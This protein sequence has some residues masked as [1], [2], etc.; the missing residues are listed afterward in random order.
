[1]QSS[2]EDRTKRIYVCIQQRDIY[3]IV[4]ALGG[5]FILERCRNRLPIL[6]TG[7]FRRY[8]CELKAWK[9]LR[10]LVSGSE[11]GRIWIVCQFM[12][13]A[14]KRPLS[15]GLQA[16][17]CITP[18]SSPQ[19]VAHLLVPLLLRADICFLLPVPYGFSGNSQNLNPVKLTDYSG[20]QS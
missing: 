5:F 3:S 1:M 19:Q 15:S 4:Y 18:F 11:R 14:I 20:E 17:C 8:N 2:L 13:P 7:Y 9:L 10:G 16:W 12:V 6:E